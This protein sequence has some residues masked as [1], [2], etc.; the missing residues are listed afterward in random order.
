MEVSTQIK[1]HRNS[2]GLTQEQLAEK[3]YVSRQTISNWETGKNYP[4]LQ[5]LLLLSTVFDITLDQLVKGDLPMMKE[6]IRQEDI[7]RMNRLSALLTLLL[8]A[9]ACAVVPLIRWLGWA[10]FIPWTVLYA[11]TMWVALRIEKLKKDNR[12][13]TYREILAFSE[14]KRLN[15]KETLEE[16]G[17]YPYQKILMVFAGAAFAAVVLWIMEMIL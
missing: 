8:V 4:D 3:V 1:E 11:F 14:G 6:E 13:R 12:I 17:K 5:S 9:C 2:Q 10:G 16:N 7:E 15:E